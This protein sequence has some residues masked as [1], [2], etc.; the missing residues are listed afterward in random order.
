[1]ELLAMVVLRPLLHGTLSLGEGD[2]IFEGL[3]R[4]TF[5]AVGMALDAILVVLY[6]RTRLPEPK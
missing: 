4:T 5:T 6:V 3:T 1:M 2:V